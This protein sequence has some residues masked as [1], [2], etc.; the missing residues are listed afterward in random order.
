MVDIKDA[1]DFLDL[2]IIGAVA[3]FFFSVIYAIVLAFWSYGKISGGW[4]KKALIKKILIRYGICMTLEAIP[5][6]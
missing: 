6:I 1:V 5:F 4:W 3:V 2:T